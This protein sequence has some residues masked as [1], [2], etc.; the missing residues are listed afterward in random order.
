MKNLEKIVESYL[1]SPFFKLNELDLV[2]EF[3]YLYVDHFFQLNMDSYLFEDY[4]IKSDT[5]N[6]VHDFL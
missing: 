4:I 3:A 5:M 6:Y 1:K 2:D